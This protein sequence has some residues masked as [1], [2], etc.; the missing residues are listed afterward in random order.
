MGPS[1][2]ATG[3]ETTMTDDAR[4]RADATQASS[5]PTPPPSPSP[6]PRP[7]PRVRWRHH[8]RKLGRDFL[9]IVAGVLTALALENWTARVKE[10]RLEA[11][12]LRA[13]ASDVQ[14]HIA[15]YDRWLVALA[16]HVEWTATIWGWANG[17]PPTQPANEVLLWVRLGGQLNL[18]AHFQDGAYE[19]L[20]GSGVLRII[21]NQALRERLINYHNS[22][23][24]RTAVMDEN[25]ARAIERYEASVA[26][27]IPPDVGW[28]AATDTAVTAADLG[29]VLAEFRSR[30]AVRHALVAM[31]ESHRFRMNAAEQGR[32]QAIEMLAALEAELAR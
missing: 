32:Q 7:G 14:E 30:P 9:L 12:Y 15:R 24:R 5:S 17:A 4:G 25:S 13:L 10:R 28:R 1:R 29:S 21:R 18:D 22:R 8:A 23:L 27:L 6:P 2:R 16:R 31:A 11:Q 19:D 3:G 20:V 26:D